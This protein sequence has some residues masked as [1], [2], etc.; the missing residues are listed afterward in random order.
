MRVIFST[1]AKQELKD[2]ALYY[3]LEHEGLGR[4]FKA[5][6]KEA[7]RRIA[8]YPHA[9]SVHRVEIRKCLLHKFPYK[10]LYSV[11]KDHV[12]ILAVAHQHRRPD[13]WVDRIDS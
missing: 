6:V 4:R 3:E 9:W 13:Y 8:R 1:L 11:E 12:V 2:A 10:L 5:E 7:A